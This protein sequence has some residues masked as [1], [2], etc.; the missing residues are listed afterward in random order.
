MVTADHSA[1]YNR[2]PQLPSGHTN[3]A[4]ESFFALLKAE[5]GTEVWLSKE[6]ARADVFTFI[7]VNYNRRRLRKDPELGYVTPLEAR[8]RYSPH[9]TLAA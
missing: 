2:N 3:A 1:F 9:T 6:A 8:L 5:I 4:A 7:E